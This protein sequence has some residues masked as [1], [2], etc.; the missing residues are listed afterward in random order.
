MQIQCLDCHCL[1]LPFI[2]LLLMHPSSLS[3]NVTASEKPSLIPRLNEVPREHSQ[4][5]P[6]LNNY[7]LVF[8]GLSDREPHKS[9]DGRGF[10]FVCLAS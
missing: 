1:T 6:S 7:C 3:F 5:Q 2:W 4:G 9:R 10:P 8:S